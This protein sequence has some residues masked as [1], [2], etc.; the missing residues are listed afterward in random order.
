MGV[1]GGGRKLE[2]FTFDQ[3]GLGVSRFSTGELEGSI[4]AALKAKRSVYENEKEVL[5]RLMK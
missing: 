1:K 4:R 5:K 3:P 2:E